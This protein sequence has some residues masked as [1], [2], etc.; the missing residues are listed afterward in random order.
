MQN[1]IKTLP[2]YINNSIF[3]RTNN[4]MNKQTNTSISNKPQISSTNNQVIQSARTS[5]TYV[6]KIQKEHIE[7]TMYVKIEMATCNQPKYE[8]YVQKQ[9]PETMEAENMC[10]PDHSRSSGEEYAVQR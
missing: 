1:E 10:S 8:M 6:I 9:N 2:K 3:Q 5:Q 7:E 4:A